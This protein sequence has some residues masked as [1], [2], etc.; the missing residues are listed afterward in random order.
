MQ[1]R[2]IWRAKQNGGNIWRLCRSLEDACNASYSLKFKGK[3]YN[4]NDK[5]N[6]FRSNQLPR[7]LKE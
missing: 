5:L 7:A 6:N 3:G 1:L 2:R 4:F